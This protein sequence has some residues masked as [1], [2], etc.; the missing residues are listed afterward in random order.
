MMT[1]KRTSALADIKL[2][3]VIP[4]AMLVFFAISAYRE[5]PAPALL[6]A[7]T[8]RPDAAPTESARANASLNAQKKEAYQALPRPE[9]R[10]AESRVTATTATTTKLTEVADSPPPPPPPPPGMSGEKNAV[11]AEMLTSS[12]KAP[13]V[14]VE[15]MPMFPGGDAA[16]L[17]YIGENVIYPEASKASM[18]QGRVIIRFCVTETGGIDLISILKGVSPEL[19]AEAARVVSTLPRF[20]PGRQGGKDVPV[21]FSVPITFTLK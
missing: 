3:G 1:K 9:N 15:E 14:V 8:A 18:I 10:Q 6:A 4:A 2:I 17:K 19:D 7:G 13:F 21:W 11:T 20:R 5:I 12:G 16:L